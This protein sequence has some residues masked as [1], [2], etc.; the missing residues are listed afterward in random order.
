MTGPEPPEE[1][2]LS[3]DEALALAGDLHRGGRLDDA[4][5]GAAGPVGRRFGGIRLLSEFGNDPG[6]EALAG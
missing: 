4:R 2:L 5:R 6:P 3:F 1:R